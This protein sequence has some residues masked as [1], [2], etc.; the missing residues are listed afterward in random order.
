ML[1]VAR[2]PTL[3]ERRAHHLPDAHERSGLIGRGDGNPGDVPDRFGL[4]PHGQARQRDDGP[5]GEAV[6]GVV[7]DE[8]AGDDHYREEYQQL[9]SEQHGTPVPVPEP[10]PREEADRGAET[11]TGD[12]RGGTPAGRWPVAADGH[13]EEHHVAALVGREHAEEAREADGLLLNYDYHWHT[14]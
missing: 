6:L 3:S 7:L 10:A 8:R 13:P 2:F 9:R 5:A 11:E 1:R 4:H 14:W 12:G